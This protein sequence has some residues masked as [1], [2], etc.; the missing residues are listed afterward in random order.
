MMPAG[1][2][3]IL[4]ALVV[5]RLYVTGADDASAACID[6]QSP[7]EGVPSGSAG[8]QDVVALIERG[9]VEGAARVLEPLLRAKPSDP[10]L[11]NF[12]GVI[13]AQRGDPVAAERHFRAA[14]RLAPTVASPY[15]NLGRLYQERPGRDPSALDKALDVYQSLLARDATHTEAGYQAAYLLV[16][17]GDLVAARRLLAALPAN[18]R[19]KPQVLA[20]QVAALAGTGDTSGAAGAAAALVAHADFVEADIAG[21]VPALTRAATD[22]NVIMLVEALDRR[23]RASPA[24]LRQLGVLQLR[25]GRPAD[26]RRTLERV[27]A[28]GRPDLALLMDLGRAAYAE[29][30]FEGALGYL[31][32]AREFDGSQAAIHFFFGIVCVELNLGAEAYESLKRAVALDPENP[33]INYALGAVAVHRHEPAESLPYFEKFV[34]LR[35]DDPRGRFALG[36]AGFYSKLFDGAIPHLQA[37]AAHEATAAGAHFFLG[38]IARQLNDLPQAEQELQI[39]LRGEPGNAEAWAELGLVQ[40]RLG[41]HAD[42]EASMLRAQAIDPDNYSA[43]LNLATLYSRTRDP[44]AE[45]Q[46]ARLAAAQEGR[47][48]RVQEFLRL[49]QV[50]P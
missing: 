44:R 7:R 22:A 36:A 30:D 4:I 41:R 46:A 31:A 45:T 2:T 21:L 23:G 26:A 16:L 37:A 40:M 15:L 17:R 27:A 42:A 39:A 29:R 28:A 11:Q 18:V 1:R 13:A 49:V 47:E 50:V 48:T 34:R 3:P 43:I 38:R 5:V 32:R 25:A 35:P 9:D 8:T 14:I 19:E 6:P 10:L 20:L 12:A 33:Y 24:I